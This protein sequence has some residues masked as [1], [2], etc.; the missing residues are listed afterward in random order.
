MKAR[1]IRRGPG[2]CGEGVYGFGIEDDE[3]LSIL[4]TFHDCQRSGYGKG[5]GI[6]LDVDGILVHGHSSYAL[7]PG[8]VAF[9]ERGSDASFTQFAI[10]PRTATYHSAVFNTDALVY[11]LADNMDVTNYSVQLHEALAAARD[12]LLNKKQATGLRMIALRN[13]TVKT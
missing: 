1:A 4:K 8:A 12:F 9:K 3:I 6:V 13:A 10:H 5:A 2:V 11:A 7:P